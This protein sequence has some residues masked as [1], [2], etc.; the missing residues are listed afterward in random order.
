MLIGICIVICLMTAGGLKAAEKAKEYGVCPHCRMESDCLICHR[1]PDF[2]LKESKPDA[3]YDYPVSGMRIVNGTAVYVLTELKSKWVREFFDYVNWHPEVWKVRIDIYCPGGGLFEAWRIVGMMEAWERGSPERIVET[4]VY[5]F[6]ASGAFMVFEGGTA[7]Y[8]FV[9]PNA[10]LMWHE[11]IS[12]K[13]L[14]IETPS[15][16]EEEAR[17]LRHLQDNI[18]EW[19]ASKS[20][21]P[22]EEIDNMVRKRELWMSGKDAV[23]YGFAD[24]FVID[25]PEVT[26]E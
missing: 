26:V 14:S 25:E 1:V 12:F 23:K 2:G 18:H 22:K 19:L 11:L 17:V 20:K 4:R 24:G 13:F 5:G 15:D 21:L 8:R 7:G 6:A 16:K 3:C 10:E 9:A